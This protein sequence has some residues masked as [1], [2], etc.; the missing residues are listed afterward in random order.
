M[1]L[2]DEAMIET[3]LREVYDAYRDNFERMYAEAR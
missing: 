3:D 2:V 1:P